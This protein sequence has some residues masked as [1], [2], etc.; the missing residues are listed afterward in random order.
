MK[1]LLALALTLCLLAATAAL[2][3]DAPQ[4]RVGYIVP[5]V[6]GN[7]HYEVITEAFLFA[8]EKKGVATNVLR[9]DPDAN[10]GPGDEADEPVLVAL[11]SLLKEGVDG[12]VAVPTTLEEAVVLAI[13]ADAADMPIVIEGIDVSAAYSSTPS[14]AGGETRPFVANVT[15][16][17]G[18]GYAAATWLEGRAYSPMMF[19]CV[20]PESDPAI[21][22]GIE[23]ALAT[24]EQL[25]LSG[26]VSAPVNTAAGGHEALEQIY[27]SGAMFYCVLADS[28]GL[29]AGCRIALREKSESMPIAAIDDSA[30][31]LIMLRDGTVDMLAC[32]PASVE[33]VQ[34]FKALY[35]YLT[36]GVLPE[37]ES[38]LVMLDVIVATTESNAGWISG[39]DYATAYALAYPEEAE[40]N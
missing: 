39:D 12:V 34:A 24:A 36:E 9:Y 13:E 3:E 2:A 30:D 5:S 32:A 20:L 15:Y 7:E 25:S 28:V 33:G 8:A 26:E 10:G 40:A 16:G 38:R 37:E 27:S 23:R 35:D 14:P 22:T 1:K 21:Q 4:L 11:K 19:H 18:A 17:D 31:A 6:T 29:A